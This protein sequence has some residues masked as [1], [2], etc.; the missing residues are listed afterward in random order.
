MKSYYSELDN[1]YKNIDIIKWINTTPSMTEAK[2]KKELK[3]F[4]KDYKISK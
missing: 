3:L 2:I 4:V 1:K